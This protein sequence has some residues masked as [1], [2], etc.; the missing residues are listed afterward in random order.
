MG[1]PGYTHTHTHTQ[2]H[3]THITHT[4]HI[5]HHTH[6]DN[7]HTHTHITD[8]TQRD[9]TH[10]HTHTH[11]HNTINCLS[12]LKKRED[13]NLPRRKKREG[14]D[15][16][17]FLAVKSPV[18]RVTHWWCSGWVGGLGGWQCGR[19]RGKFAYRAWR[20]R[21]EC[22]W[23]TFSKVLYTVTLYSKYTR[24]LAFENL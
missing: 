14:T 1:A 11:T 7:T 15:F 16:R 12:C 20:G 5:T 10:T 9:H 24:A 4:S 3:H 8:H 6:T 19:G 17:K 2:T 13:C 22:R 23:Q 21:R 18:T